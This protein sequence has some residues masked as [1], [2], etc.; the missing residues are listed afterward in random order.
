MSASGA[1]HHAGRNPVATLRALA[2]A[3]GRQGLPRHD[4]HD[5]GDG[6]T[7]EHQRKRVRIPPDGAA[8]PIHGEDDTKG[9][10]SSGESGS[11]ASVARLH[12]G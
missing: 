1:H 10:N 4:E 7:G 9:N 11:P 8:S 5:G 12:G 2:R 3:K 6:E